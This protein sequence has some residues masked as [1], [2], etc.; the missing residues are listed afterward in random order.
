MPH[1]PLLSQIGH[2]AAAALHPRWDFINIVQVTQ[3]PVCRRV[4]EVLPLVWLLVADCSEEHGGGR[5]RSQRVPELCQQTKATLLSSQTY[6]CG[7]HQTEVCSVR[8]S[9]VPNFGTP[10]KLSQ[11]RLPG[12]LAPCLSSAEPFHPVS[13]QRAQQFVLFIPPFPLALFHCSRMVPYPRPPARL[14]LLFPQR[15]RTPGQTRLLPPSK[16]SFVPIIDTVMSISCRPDEMCGRGHQ[17]IHY[18]KC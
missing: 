12:Q 3:R 15:L 13:L 5:G 16:T 18:R 7:V 8:L 14:R 10:Y 2:L 4:T 11:L 9:L 17:R 1:T 6:P